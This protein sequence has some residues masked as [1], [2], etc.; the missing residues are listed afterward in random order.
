MS[1]GTLSLVVMFIAFAVVGAVLL[2]QLLPILQHV[3]AS[4]EALS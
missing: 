1:A 4:I 2:S 3:S